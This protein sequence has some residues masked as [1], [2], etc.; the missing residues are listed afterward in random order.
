MT[1]RLVA[2]LS[3]L[4]QGACQQRD[5]ISDQHNATDIVTGDARLAASTNRACKLFSAAEAG[6]LMG[7]VAGSAEN[8]AMGSGCSWAGAR[9]GQFTV[10]ILP[11]AE[12]EP[13][14]AAAGFHKIATPGTEGFVVPDMGGWV[15]GAIVGEN[16]VR[17]TLVGEASTETAAVKALTQAASR[18][19]PR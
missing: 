2:A 4:A 15:A 1:C 18:S 10:T 16:A 12:H 5:A 13:A 19:A 7:E 6:N 3:L 11:A 17:I 8:A 14:T 9:G